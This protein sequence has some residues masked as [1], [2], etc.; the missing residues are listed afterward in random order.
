MTS[1]ASNDFAYL[2]FVLLRCW[3]KDLSK[4]NHFDQ[5]SPK[6]QKAGY[7]YESFFFVLNV[8]V[9]E[10]VDLDRVFHILICVHVLKMICIVILSS[11]LYRR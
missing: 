1:H 8:R 5:E 6:L 10:Q 7:E 9:H 11:N 4:Q 2:Q 3:L